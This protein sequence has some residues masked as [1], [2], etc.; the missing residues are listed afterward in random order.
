M[1]AGA[2]MVR[3]R[4]FLLN[5]GGAT[6]ALCALGTASSKDA[7]PTPKGPR[8][9][10]P[11]GPDVLDPSL[12]DDRLDCRSVS[13]E[14]PTG[15]RGGGGKSSRGRKGRPFHIL[16]PG[17]KVV[18]AQIGGRGT[19]R[20]WWMT[21]GSWPPEVMRAL[22]LEVFYD[23]LSEP[24]ISVPILDFFGLPHGRLAEYYSAMISAN[25]GRGLNCHIPMPFAHSI[26][27]E[28]TNESSRHVTLYYQIDYTLEPSLA[29]SP[30][31]LHV[32][33]RRQ[34]P[35]AIGRDFVI[36]EGLKGPGRF[37]GCS[38]GIRVL[39][40]GHWYGEGEVKIYRDG[41]GEFPTYCGTGLEDY[42]GSAY[43]LG[44]HHGIYSGSPIYIPAPSP[45]AA[46]DSGAGPDFASFYRWHLPDPVMFSDDLRVT[47]QQI[48]SVFFP[49]GQEAAFEAFK[50]DHPAA[51]RGWV[52][53]L[54]FGILGFGLVEQSDDYCASAFVYCRQP[55]PVARFDTDV[56][57]RDVGLLAIEAKPKLISDDMQ[58]QGAIKLKKY[59]DQ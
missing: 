26:R 8:S 36:A 52:T 12:I 23:G 15:S 47:I 14:N 35:T 57:V 19:L 2:F 22:R 53:D 46:A 44:R 32:T 33:F 9:A 10:S 48:G 3:R 55:Q 18:L 25:E 59:W 43:G 31:Y 49:K 13:F 51:G 41:D 16:D 39:N 7:A 45:N 5:S 27:V 42:V 29:R 20:H 30:S 4:E 38:V 17:E 58:D 56:A 1:Q 6:A 28:F 50:S 34:N 24:S 37:L 40:K 54:G 11:P 21:L